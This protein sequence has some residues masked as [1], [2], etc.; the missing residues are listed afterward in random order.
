MKV[1]IRVDASF[2]IG[3][4]HLMRC[5]TLADYLSSKKAEVLF[6]CRNLP[7]HLQNLLAAKRFPVLQL[8]S[9]NS[10]T[11]EEAE[12]GKT[13]AH[14]DWLGVSQSSDA[15]NCKR[16]LEGKV[17]DWLVVDH[18]ALDSTWEKALRQ[19][20]K[21][22]LVIDDLADREHDCDVLLDQNY[23]PRMTDRYTSKVPDSCL[24]LTGPKYALLRDEFRSWRAKVSIR[25]DGVRRVLVFFGGVD[26]PNFTGLCLGALKA[27]S[28]RNYA[29]DVVVGTQH[30]CLA[31]IGALCAEQGYD[32]H[33]QSG[34]MAELMA[35]S[36][37]AI[38]ATGATSWERCCLGLPSITISLADNQIEIAL[39]LQRMGASIYLGEMSQVDPRC[40]AE[41]IAILVA[42]PDVVKSMSERAFEL[43][44]GGGVVRVFEAMAGRYAHIN[45]LH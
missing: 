45:S 16:V 36:D 41:Q 18:Y 12:A 15:E 40:L 3:T 20:T 7:D 10:E 37:I 35:R 6:L 8:E 17:L 2:Q 1:G 39:G 27:S 28:L 4:G 19:N 38:G 44:D 25:K 32:L 43:V 33:V 11:L 42:R 23:Y 14:A 24:M 29:V 30:P 9:G 26:A 22:V 21:S 31:E 34:R 5:L 13:L